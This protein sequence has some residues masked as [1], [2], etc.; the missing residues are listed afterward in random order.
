MPTID[1]SMHP[2][3]CPSLDPTSPTFHPTVKPTVDP[4]FTPTIDPTSPLG[5]GLPKLESIIGNILF[6][7]HKSQ[8]AA[9]ENVLDP[10]HIQ[11]VREKLFK[12][13]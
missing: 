5:T 4:S 7:S 1:P 3:F 2:T 13:M 10:H 8:S 9:I 12:A 11:K 6:K